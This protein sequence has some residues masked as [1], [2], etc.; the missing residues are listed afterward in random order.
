ML[1]SKGMF[2][3]VIGLSNGGLTCWCVAKFNEVFRAVNRLIHCDRTCCCVIQLE[4]VFCVGISISNCDL[5]CW[6][7]IDFQE[8]F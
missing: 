5:T 8:M 4:E 6:C 3:M 7:A 2:C 1:G